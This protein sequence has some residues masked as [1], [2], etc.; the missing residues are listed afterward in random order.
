MEIVKFSATKAA[1]KYEY[2]Q[3]YGGREG[4]PVDAVI[5]HSIHGN[6]YENN[7][8]V[9]PE[10]IFFSRGVSPH[11][12]I[13]RD[14]A[15][16][17]FVDEEFAAWHAGKSWFDGRDNWNQP[18]IG[19]ELESFG[20]INALKEFDM[21]KS[22]GYHLQS[23]TVKSQEH[24]DAF[25]VEQYISLRRLL[26]DIYARYEIKYLLPHSDIAPGRKNDPGEDFDWGRLEKSGYRS[27]LNF[28]RAK[29]RFSPDL[30]QG[31]VC[32]SLGDDG[33]GVE[34]L[35]S[36]LQGL[37]YGLEATGV[38]DEA[39]AR[40]VAAFKLHYAAVGSDYTS[41]SAEDYTAL[42]RLFEFR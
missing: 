41:W 38:Y 7:R 30:C 26:D 17:Q 29:E 19:I 8:H 15:I 5:L 31:E 18:S 6:F 27:Y 4:A 12:F 36:I 14:G 37:G 25:S 32:Y 22:L 42:A 2:K 1:Q 33:A 9:M 21:A 13:K 3:N 24:K 16:L 20:D 35:Q 11:Y 39:T 23:K 28:T 34:R 10:E 40:V